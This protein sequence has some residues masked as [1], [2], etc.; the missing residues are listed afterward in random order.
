MTK[1]KDPR[2]AKTLMEAVLLAKP[3]KRRHKDPL[4]G[5]KRKHSTPWRVRQLRSLSFEILYR[6][7]DADN[8][9]VVET[10]NRTL[11]RA[12]ARMGNAT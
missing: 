7:Y 10:F 9:W 3:R 11:A 8:E 4:A 12:I 6:V 2:K 5:L 1:P